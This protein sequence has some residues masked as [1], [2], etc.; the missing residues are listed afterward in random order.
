MNEDRL[1]EE[2]DRI[3]ELEG[4]ASTLADWGSVQVPLPDRGYSKQNIVVLAGNDY[5][6]S[7]FSYLKEICAIAVE[8]VLARVAHT[9]EIP[10]A[11]IFERNRTSL[12][13]EARQVAMYVLRVDCKL[14][15]EE[16]GMI[17]ARDHT[18][19]LH[20]SHKIVRLIKQDPNGALAKRITAIRHSQFG[21]SPID[22]PCGKFP[23]IWTRQVRNVKRARV[24]LSQ[25]K[26]SA[27]SRQKE[28][29]AKM[30]RL[31]GAMV[32]TE[33]LFRKIH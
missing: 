11:T 1:F 3:Q 21:L 13:A 30:N 25:S 28:I 4:L 22:W 5:R 23:Q 26:S 6:N 10:I 20:G 32:K 12:V 31:I 17:M 15:I 24:R 18:T 2:L 9:F 27:P 19:V 16:I 7:W 14:S 8:I 33:R 29:F